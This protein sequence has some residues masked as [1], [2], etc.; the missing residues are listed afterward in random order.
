MIEW[1]APEMLEEGRDYTEKV[2]VYSFGILMYEIFTRRM[3]YQEVKKRFEVIPHVLEGHRPTFS[4]EEIP[5]KGLRNLMQSCWH[6][7]PR[8]RPS[9]SV[10]LDK[11]EAAEGKV[12]KRVLEESQEV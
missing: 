7:T 3:P 11:L 4:D 10:I 6:K 12:Q 5:F 1:M 9:F 2:D 8:K